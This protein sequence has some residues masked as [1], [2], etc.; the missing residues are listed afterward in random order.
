M[1][2]HLE[3][4]RKALKKSDI[5]VALAEAL[6]S[7]AEDLRRIADRRDSRPTAPRPWTQFPYTINVPS[8]EA[9]FVWY[10]S[11]SSA[12]GGGHYEPGPRTDGV[13]A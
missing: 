1:T 10:G 5:E 11:S 7:V 8:P 3:K 2:D 6:V 4:A 12:G 9:P 13:V